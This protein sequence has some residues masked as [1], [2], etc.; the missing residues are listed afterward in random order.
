M[1]VN[2]TISKTT[3]T[4]TITTGTT[5]IK[6]IHLNELNTAITTLQNLKTNVNNYFE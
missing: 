4:D 3:F 1:A 2:S 6:A 5:I